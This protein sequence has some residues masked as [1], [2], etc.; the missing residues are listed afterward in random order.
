M[1]ISKSGGSKS[2]IVLHLFGPAHNAAGHFVESIMLVMESCVLEFQILEFF[3]LVGTIALEEVGQVVNAFTDLLMQFL[4][5]CLG[6]FFQF[7]QLHLQ[8]ALLFALR[9]Q[10]LLE[11]IHGH[12]H[13]EEST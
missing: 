13:G 2:H 8:F 11:V 3:V 6:A 12:L 1:K 9:F 10:G 7:L 5:L 4:E